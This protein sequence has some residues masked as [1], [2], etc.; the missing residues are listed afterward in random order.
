MHLC[1]LVIDFGVRITQVSRRRL[2]GVLACGIANGLLYERGSDLFVGHPRL[3][4]L[5]LFSIPVLAGLLTPQTPAFT[6]AVLAL[7]SYPPL[8]DMAP[9]P[10]ILWPFYAAAMTHYTTGLNHLFEVT[11]AFGMAAAIAMVAALLMCFPYGCLVYVGWTAR[12]MSIKA[13]RLRA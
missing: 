9:I 4:Y 1:R 8:N 2:V 3:F 11:I 10:M 6:T 12:I 13:L 7:T 5:C